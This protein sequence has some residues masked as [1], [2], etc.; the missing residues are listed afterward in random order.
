MRKAKS[1]LL[2]N[3][4]VFVA[5]WDGPNGEIILIARDRRRRLIGEPYTVPCG[6]DPVAANDLMWARVDAADPMP[7]RL[8]I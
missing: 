8:A 7:L 5:Q 6:S 3:R 1:E 2:E 4:G